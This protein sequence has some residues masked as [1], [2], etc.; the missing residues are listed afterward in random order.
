VPTAV[1]PP[2]L[3]RGA[4]SAKYQERLTFRD[5]VPTEA[6]VCWMSKSS[7][8][9]ARIRVGAAPAILMFQSFRTTDPTDDSW[10]HP[11]PLPL[12]GTEGGPQREV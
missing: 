5:Y 11:I 2:W 10:L 1:P 12:S 3:P 4:N 7:G 9:W 6:R 8:F